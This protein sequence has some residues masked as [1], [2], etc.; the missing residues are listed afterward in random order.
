MTK[1]ISQLN[2]IPRPIDWYGV[3]CLIMGVGVFAL[4]FPLT[5][6]DPHSVFWHF[7]HDRL[8]QALGWFF[9]VNEPWGFPLGNIESMIYPVGITVSYTDSIPLLAL[10]TK[11]LA[12]LIGFPTQF[13]GI[14]LLVCFCLQ[15]FFAYKLLTSLGLSGLVSL[16]GSLFF[17]FSPVL[18]A[19]FQHTSLCAHWLI[20]L[21]LWLYFRDTA[22]EIYR[23][24]VWIFLQVIA[25]LIALYLVPFTL[26]IAIASFFGA[27]KP[28]Y[29]LPKQLLF[30]LTSIFFV[31]WVF[32]Y[33]GNQILM[34]QG[35][36]EYSADLLTMINPR[37]VSIYQN[38]T[39]SRFIDGW[40]PG[41]G[42]YEG[43]GYLGVGVLLLIGIFCIRRTW[44]SQNIRILIPII[45][46]ASLLAIYS[47]SSQVTLAG[48]KVLDLG[49]FYKYL[50]TICHTFRASGR[51]IWLLYYL[52]MALGVAW[53]VKNLKL[54]W[55]IILLSIALFLQLYD[56]SSLIQDDYR[57]RQTLYKPP[58]S[59]A[60]EGLGLDYDTIA[61]YPPQ[62]NAECPPGRIYGAEDILLNSITGLWLAAREKMNINSG[63][64]ARVFL[65]E[66]KSACNLFL[67]KIAQGEIDHRTVYIPESGYQDELE[68]LTAGKLLCGRIERETF[69][70]SRNHN[71]RLLRYLRDI[72]SS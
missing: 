39:A 50:G 49:W 71:T 59:S 24:L 33:L 64:A 44:F 17:S 2:R 63:T 15:G 1:D 34:I 45:V 69:C 3:T 13:F 30:L 72:S 25:C 51:F 52:L 40:V 7:D 68:S 32:G 43:F 55:Q 14:W 6:L 38:L 29:K 26:V 42:Q 58:T 23:P 56:I 57:Y 31:L 16:I 61:L 20:L 35:F 18:L 19:R 62:V 36:G 12:E 8:G 48:T 66:E 21:G 27:G 9:W 22:K 46:G 54:S 65:N 28:W 4:L 70:I 37:L 47:L 5:C 41:E 11:P 60:F 10:I 67:A 53:S